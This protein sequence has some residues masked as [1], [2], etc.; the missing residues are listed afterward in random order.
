MKTNTTQE[1]WKRYFYSGIGHLSHTGEVIQK[2]AKEL[3][4]QGKTTEADGRKIIHNAMDGMEQKYNEAV[5][6]LADF[7]RSEITSLQAR[8]GKMEKQVTLKTKKAD[9]PV[10]H[11]AKSSARNNNHASR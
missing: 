8:L 3:S 1:N 11:M 10:R 5:H 2:S 6:K 4:R 9:Y 7:T